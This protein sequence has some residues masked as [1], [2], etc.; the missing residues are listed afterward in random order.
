MDYCSLTF[1]SLEKLILV[2]HPDYG[3]QPRFSS[4]S[5][6]A[7]MFTLADLFSVDLGCLR[8]KISRDFYLCY[9]FFRLTSKIIQNS[10]FLEN[11]S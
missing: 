6:L 2:L 4:I 1:D 9:Y 5:R 3:K 7:G 8:K 10:L 11:K